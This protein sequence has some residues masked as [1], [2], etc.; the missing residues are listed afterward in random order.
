M[1]NENDIEYKKLFKCSTFLPK[2]AKYYDGGTHMMIAERHTMTESYKRIFY[3]TIESVTYY[4]SSLYKYIFIPLVAITLSLLL[5]NCVYIKSWIFFGFTVPFFLYTLL[6][7]IFVRETACL[8]VKTKTSE[9]IFPVDKKAN[10]L[11]LANFIDDKIADYQENIPD[12][13]LHSRLLRINKKDKKS[14]KDVKRSEDDYELLK[15]DG[16]SILDSDSE[17]E[18]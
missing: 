10:I 16:D 3:S 9:V 4:K 17:E 8:I 5:I 13:E 2:R 14:F 18:Q 6:L 11:T 15:N 1:T 7:Y 12:E